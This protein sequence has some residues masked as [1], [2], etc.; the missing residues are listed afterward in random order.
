MSYQPDHI[1]AGTQLGAPL[2]VRGPSDSFVHQQGAVGA[3]TRTPAVVGEKFLVRFPD[4]FEALFVSALRA[5][6]GYAMAQFKKIEQDIRNSGELKWKHA[7]PVLRTRATTLRES[8]VPV[9][10]EARREQMLSV[11][12]GK[13]PSAELDASRKEMRRNFEGA[14]LET[15]LPERADYEAANSHLIKA[16]QEIV[17]SRT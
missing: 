6:K 3:G 7:M 1:I 15:K 11:K 12:L 10:V 2:E 5:F 13:E 8:H 9:R 16:R 14:L 17:K 4:G